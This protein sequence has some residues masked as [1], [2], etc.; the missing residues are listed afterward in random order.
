V[1]CRVGKSGISGNF[2]FAGG[3][4]ICLGRITVWSRWTGFGDLSWLWRWMRD[5]SVN[6]AIRWRAGDGMMEAL[7]DHSSVMRIRQRWGSGRFRAMFARMLG[8][9]P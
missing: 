7:P 3:C 8:G 6:L 2:P 5:A 1:R 4:A 9:L